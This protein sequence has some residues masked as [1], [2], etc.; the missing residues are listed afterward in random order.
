MV[1]FKAVKTPCLTNT[2]PELLHEC[3]SSVA[4]GG[5]HSEINSPSLTILQQK[6]S[7]RLLE[8]SN[9]FY[10]LEKTSQ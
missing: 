10:G 9:Q 8:D 7:Q 4:T 5:W 1:V 2:N 3:L 6:L